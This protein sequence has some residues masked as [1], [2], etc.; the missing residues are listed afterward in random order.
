MKNTIFYPNITGATEKQQLSQLKGWLYQLTDQLNLYLGE[1][2]TGGSTALANPAGGAAGSTGETQVDLQTLKSLI[3]KSGT[4]MQVVSQAVEKRLEGKYVTASEFGTYSRDTSQTI[5]ANS[6]GFR[7]ALEELQQLTSQV[8]GIGDSLVGVNAHIKAGLL[9]YDEEGV[10]V[11]GIELGQR[12]FR[13]GEEFFHKY[14]RFTPD[15]LAF[16]DANGNQ[17]AYISDRKLY[18]ANVHITG[19]F[20]KG[21]FEDTV[22]ADG[23]IVTR[24]I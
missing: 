10:P 24:W 1:D 9:E 5:T 11:H 15:R 6:Q 23:S 3:I 13:D 21:R 18:I 14:A 17:V 16:Y 4:V 22:Q 20:L 8:E 12:K 2:P 7:M 19:T